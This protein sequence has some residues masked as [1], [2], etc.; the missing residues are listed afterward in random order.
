MPVNRLKLLQNW[1]R[2]VDS[3]VEV[4]KR[5]YHDAE[6]YLFGGAAEGRLTILSDVDVLVVFREKLTTEK[7]VEVLAR[8]WEELE[9]SGVPPY[10]PLD[11][12]VVGRDELDAYRRRAR[13]VRLD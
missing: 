12:H 10:Y 3:V 1:R 9:R 8:L 7:R 2:V 11:I 13:L 4:V 5:L 6:V